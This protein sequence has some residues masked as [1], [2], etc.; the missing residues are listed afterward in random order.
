MCRTRFRA[1]GFT[2]IE[3]LV[4]IVIIGILMSLLLPAV[5]MARAAGRKASCA[6]NLHQLGIA[7]KS[8]RSKNIAIKAGSWRSDLEPFVAE[9]TDVYLCPEVEVDE[10]ESFGMNNKAHLFGVGDSYKILMLDYRNSIAEIVGGTAFRRCEEWETNA[11]FRH[12]GTCNV[13]YFDGHVDRL[14]PSD[15]DPCD[16]GDVVGGLGGQSGSG[17]A[18]STSEY[19]TDWVPTRYVP[20]DPEEQ[21]IPGLLAEYRAT[22]NA[23][24]P[25]N[26]DGPPDRKRVDLDL[27]SPFGSGYANGP[28][29]ANYP[30]NP[31]P[32][33]QQAFTVTWRGQIRAP[34]SGEYRLW[35]SHDDFCWITVYGQ[36]VYADTW[37]NGPPFTYDPSTPLTLVAGEWVDIEVK[38]HQWMQGGNHLRVQWEGPGVARQDIPRDAFRLPPGTPAVN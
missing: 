31:L 23:T 7:F 35:V 38:L 9:Q 26:W 15:T 37:W 21:S 32:N 2:L 12:M 4:V 30:S 22:P 11:A 14:G 8:A 25:G 19:R 24:T 1:S 27:N 29:G 17:T 6:N 28:Q 16:G 36:Q 3:L 13:L 10:G 20:N 18:I 5:Q 33:P 34:Q